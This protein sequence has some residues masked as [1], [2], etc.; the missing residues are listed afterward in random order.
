MPVGERKRREGDYLCVHVLCI[1]EPRNVKVYYIQKKKNKSIAV[2]GNFLTEKIA[3][4]T[5]L[6]HIEVIDHEIEHSY[7]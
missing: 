5:I 3:S 4:H 7:L 1:F 2:Q 6:N